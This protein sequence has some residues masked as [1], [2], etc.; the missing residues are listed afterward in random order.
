MQKS[1]NRVER[2]NKIKKGEHGGLPLRVSEKNLPETSRRGRPPCLPR[3]L[4]VCLL[5][6]RSA[7]VIMQAWHERHF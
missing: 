7:S 3:F 6:P 4:S 5:T 1:R 2:A